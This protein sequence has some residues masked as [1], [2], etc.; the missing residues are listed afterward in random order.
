M[1]KEACACESKLAV[2]G[3]RWALE[4]KA[5]CMLEHSRSDRAQ[6]GPACSIDEA[7]SARR[8]ELKATQLCT[9]AS[10]APG[11]VREQLAQNGLKCRPRCHIETLCQWSHRPD[12]ADAEVKVQGWTQ[13]A[14]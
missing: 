14:L 8:P 13:R 5:G 6:A 2:N 1:L 3:L 4:V 9:P 11:Q 12:R 7:R 10:L